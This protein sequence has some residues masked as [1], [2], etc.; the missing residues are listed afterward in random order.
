MIPIQEMPDK[1]KFQFVERNRAMVQ[2]C[3]R[4]LVQ[5]QLGVEELA[6]LERRWRAGEH[7]PAAGAS[8]N[9]RYETAY[10]NFIHTGKTIYAYMREQMGEE[11]V[12]LLQDAEVE[13]LKQE[14]GGPAIWML[15]LLRALLPGRAFKLTAEQFAY[16]LQWITP[17]AL[18]TLDAGSAVY[19]IPRCKILDDPDTDDLCFIGCQQVY[20]RW[21][22]EQFGVRMEYDRRGT[23]CTAT[24]TPLP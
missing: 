10:D 8:W 15:S 9:E 14:N 5:E 17:F 23:A 11:G 20:P 22:A 18:E 1:E 3:A 12:S 2:R 6:E 7:Q 4:R 21:A 24:L 19:E 16:Q 13:A